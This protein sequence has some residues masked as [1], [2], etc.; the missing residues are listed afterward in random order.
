MDPPQIEVSLAGPDRLVDLAP[1]FGRA[2]VKE[3]MMCWPM[4]EEPDPAERFTRCFGWFLESALE[5]GL[6][7]EAGTARGAAVWVPPGRFDAWGDHPWN[8]PRIR[9]E[10]DDGGCRYDEFWRWVDRHSPRGPLWQ[11]DSI[12]V[13]PVVQGHGYGGALILA[14]LARARSNGVGA[15]LSTGTE[16]NVTIYGRYGFRVVDDLDAPDGGPHIWFMRWEP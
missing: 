13:D 9:A 3:P 2:F 15:F 14:G 16:R 4:G 11:L 7:W 5:L 6:V 10:A 8:Q 12:A 1:V